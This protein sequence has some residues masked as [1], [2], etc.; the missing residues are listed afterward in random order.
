MFESVIEMSATETRT[1]EGQLGDALDAMP[2]RGAHLWLLVL[3]ALGALLDAM[4]Q[5]NIGL[6]APRLMTQWELAGSQ[7]GLLS[8]ATFLGMAIGSVTAGLT[9]DRYGRRFTNMYNLLLFTVGSYVGFSSFRN[10]RA[11]F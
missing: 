9:N 11:I 3:V 5:S 8:S 7:L 6:I 2:V 10:R 4:T 1:L